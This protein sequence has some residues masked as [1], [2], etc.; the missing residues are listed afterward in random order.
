MS[1][2]GDRVTLTSAVD[3]RDGD[4][5]NMAPSPALST[6]RVGGGCGFVFWERR[7]EPDL[8]DHLITVL[9]APGRASDPHAQKI[10][11]GIRKSRSARKPLF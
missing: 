6:A 8:V 3:L 11:S 9:L 5:V 1:S 7:R 10:R 2:A 4:R